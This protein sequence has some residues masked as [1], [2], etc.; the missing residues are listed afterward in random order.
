[1][2]AVRVSCMTAF[3]SMLGLGQVHAAPSPFD[4]IPI[5]D[6]VLA[7]D[8]HGA[9]VWRRTVDLTLPLQLVRT[10][11]ASYIIN[12][13]TTIDSRGWLANQPDDALSQPEASSDYQWSTPQL[14]YDTYSG[15]YSPPVFDKKG[16]AWTLLDDAVSGKTRV[17]EYVASKGKWKLVK[18]LPDI[19]SSGRLDIDPNGNVTIVL[20]SADQTAGW[21]I[22][23]VRYEP[24]LG[25]SNPEVIYSEPYV[26]NA[27]LN[28]DLVSD[29]AGNAVVTAGEMNL[30]ALSIVY[31][32]EQHAWLPAER[33]P[34]PENYAG[35]MVEN[36]ALARSPN[37]KYVQLVYLAGIASAPNSVK[38]GYYSHSFDRAS[39]SF[40][41]A[42][43]LPQSL[44]TA[45]DGNE[46]G[47]NYLDQAKTVVANDGAVTVIW[48]SGGHVP[49][50]LI[51]VYGSRRVNGTWKNPVRL[52]KQ[53]MDMTTDFSS[54]DIDSDGRVAA[55]TT[56]GNGIDQSTFVV[57]KY[58]PDQGW[59]TDVAASWSYSGL[60]TRSRILW[61]DG[62]KLVG[63]YMVVPQDTSSGY[64]G[65]SYSVYQNGTWGSSAVVDPAFRDV[66]Y[67]SLA[68][69]PTGLSLLEFNPA[70]NVSSVTQMRASFL[71]VVQ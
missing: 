54:V 71:E 27:F 13:K 29:K 46:S 58:V 67:Q 39:L 68:A 5:G 50:K 14:I 4:L 45:G 1:M 61:F 2:W 8:R 30:G 17:M 42:E 64:P 34:L 9:P 15:I 65:F 62:G 31:S 12:G 24:A 47:E 10:S 59:S 11:P 40:G 37:G 6:S 7:L 57:F 63:T 53:L 60:Q 44:G 35:G 52:S 32:A 33:I 56:S 16:N 55:C 36:I 28:Y 48:N 25:W 26:P 69:S 19:W 49:E 70:D 21:A 20:I 41:A 18:T 22:N 43:A 3:V 51:G 38:L 66:F 23:A